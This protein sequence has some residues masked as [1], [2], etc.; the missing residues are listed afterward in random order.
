VSSNG[1]EDHV[2]M[3]A[4]AA[5]KSRRV[6]ENVEQVLGIELMTAVQALAFRRPGRMSEDLETVVDA[7]R[8][9]VKFVGRDRV[10][11]PDLHRAAAFV[12]KFDWK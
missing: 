8:E 7:F 6:L 5:T 11:Y 4:N 9:E 3:G 10:L 1:Q 2:S 12:R